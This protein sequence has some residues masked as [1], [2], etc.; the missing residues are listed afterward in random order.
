MATWSRCPRP[1][2]SR[3]YSA[4]TMAPG[5]HHP[6]PGVA[7]VGAGLHR[8]R[9][10][11]ASDARAAGKAL[12][13]R[14]EAGEVPVRRILGEP[15]DLRVDEPGL[16]RAEPVPAQPEAVDHA[17]A[18][19]LHEHVGPLR[20]SQRGAQA[21][22]RLQVKLD[23]FLARVVQV[24]RNGVVAVPAARRDHFDDLGAEERQH[25][26]RRR[27]RDLVRQVQHPHP[28]KRPPLVVHQSLHPRRRPGRGQ[29]GLGQA[30]RGQAGSRAA[31]R[32]ICSRSGLSRSSLAVPQ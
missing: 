17:G 5:Q 10:R 1:S 16:Q 14:V 28:V 20:Q 3:W 6:R 23:G 26:R 31:G 7:H 8:Q 29:A 21:L 32:R 15:L 18:E 25:E 24:E 27:P 19:V 9:V 4:A 13:D 11:F 2:F 30:G 22:V 12:R